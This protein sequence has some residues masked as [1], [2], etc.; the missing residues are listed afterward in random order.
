MEGVKCLLMLLS[1]HDG[2]HADT[3]DTFE[4]TYRVSAVSSCLFFIGQCQEA[5]SRAGPFS[6]L[7][8][9]G[10]KWRQLSEN[11]LEHLV[12]VLHLSLCKGHENDSTDGRT[13]QIEKHHMF[14]VASKSKSD[15]LTPFNF[16]TIYIDRS[17]IINISSMTAQSKTLR[18]KHH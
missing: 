11:W 5:S 8:F 3:A 2:Y 7:R 14:S 15:L 4:S 9:S 16:E 18:T 13:P 1:P 12:L 17:F 10:A 6:R